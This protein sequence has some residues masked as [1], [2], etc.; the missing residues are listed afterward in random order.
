MGSSK[1]DA[2]SEGSSISSLSDDGECSTDEEKC[3]DR[4]RSA[5]RS[6]KRR[7]S[8]RSRSRS[9]SRDRQS[10]SRSRSR[11]YERRRSSNR[12]SRRSRSRSK[13]MTP[14]HRHYRSRSP[15]GHERQRNNSR[16]NP[17]PSRCL[18]VFGMNLHTSER[19]L[20]DFFDRFGAIENV[21]VI[22]DQATHKSRGFAFVYFESVEDAIEAKNRAAGAEIDGHN[23]RIDFSF[24]SRAHA[25]T[26][27]IYM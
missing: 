23:V 16:E 26:P 18:G 1:K 15:R 3:N 4:R 11:N 19:D 17:S 9:R 21:Q 14:S 22:Y 12:E 7:R 27:G 5:S 20:R 25:P 24:T 2:K 10:R 8:R 13:S 6:P